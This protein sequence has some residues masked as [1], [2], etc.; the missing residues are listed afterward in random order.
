[1]PS[2]ATEQLMVSF[3]VHLQGG[4]SKA[5]ALRAAQLYVMNNSDYTDP[6]YWAAFNLMGD[7]R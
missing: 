3:Y 6:W 2:L 7:W 5:N 1:V 4:T